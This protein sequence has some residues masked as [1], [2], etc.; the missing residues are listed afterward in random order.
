MVE[1]ETVLKRL[2]GLAL[3]AGQRLLL[4]QTRANSARLRVLFDT[5][6]ELQSLQAG[7]LVLARQ[8]FDVR[9]QL[10][11]ALRPFEEL[12]AQRG[13]DF[14][15]RWDTP[16]RMLVGDPARVALLLCGVVEHLL[17]T[18][19]RGR[20]IV[21]VMSVATDAAAAGQCDLWL[22]VDCQPTDDAGQPPADPA[23][24]A[25]QALRAALVVSQRLC[26]AMAG[27]LTI[28]WRHD[29][30]P[31]VRARLRC[32][33]PSD[34]A[35][36]PAESVRHDDGLARALPGARILVVDDNRTNQ[37]LVE[38]WL[39]KEGATVRCAS[40]G[41]AA[42]TAVS[43]QRFDAILMDVSMPQMNGLDAT[44]AIRAMGLRNSQPGND[45]TRLP[46]IGLSAHAQP[47]DRDRC[48]DSGMTDYIVK[49]I[50]RDIL[51]TK[52]AALLA[53]HNSNGHTR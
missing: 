40:D 18:T 50:Q 17:T 8:P 45:L 24:E 53:R 41:Q 7:T 30:G 42:V 52:V 15:V 12:A 23:D 16:Q 14:F 13:L 38:R 29:Q 35:L 33:I 49:P 51:L 34:A 39:N 25:V 1:L 44:R 10:S 46:I 47:E 9:Q 5:L 28:V 43:E 48:I 4:E 26:E 6:Q 2:D 11:A 37:R 20:V 31:L 27:E 19:Q 3:S 36:V 21:D 32:D 22:A